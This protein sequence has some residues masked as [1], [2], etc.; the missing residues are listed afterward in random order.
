[1]KIAKIIQYR[2][3][4][5]YIYLNP[6]NEVWCTYTYSP[7]NNTYNDIEMITSASERGEDPNLFK[8]FGLYLQFSTRYFLTS[9]CPFSHVE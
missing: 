3:G 4:S 1:M 5:L 7:S 6:G 8:T 9:R 2:Y